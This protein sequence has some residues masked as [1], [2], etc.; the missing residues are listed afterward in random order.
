MDDEQQSRLAGWFPLGRLGRRDDVATPALLLL[1]DRAAWITGIPIDVAGGGN[2]PLVFA[3][4]NGPR[5]YRVT[6][7]RASHSSLHGSLM[8][9]E[10]MGDDMR[11]L[12]SDRQ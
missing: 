9:I 11:Q 2:H 12:A 8:T 4:V 5:L 10:L 1:S 3:E 6:Q 7:G